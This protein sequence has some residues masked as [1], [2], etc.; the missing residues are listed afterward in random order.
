MKKL[1]QKPFRLGGHYISSGYVV[2]TEQYFDV[3]QIIQHE[4]YN[5]PKQLSNDI[6]LLKLSI[7]VGL[8][9]LSDGQFQ[10]QFN[11]IRSRFVLFGVLYYYIF[12][13]LLAH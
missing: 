10:R 9:C 1:D 7:P 5:S 6:A 8:V 13:F 4:N 11:Y 3:M 12:R 2:G